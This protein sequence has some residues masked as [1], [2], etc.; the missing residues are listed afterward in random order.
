MPGVDRHRIVDFRFD[1]AAKGV[2][3]QLPTA[4]DFDETEALTRHEPFE[5]LEPRLQSS[6][7]SGAQIATAGADPL[8][9]R[10]DIDQKDLALMRWR[11]ADFTRLAVVGGVGR[12]EEVL[13]GQQSFHAA[14]QDRPIRGSA[15]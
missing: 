2:D 12:E 11:E 4:G 13:A 10:I 1:Q 8:G 3:Q 9:G 6:G 7:R 14:Q 5:S 15:W